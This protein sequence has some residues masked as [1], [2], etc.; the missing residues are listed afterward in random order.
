VNEP[1][2]SRIGVDAL[3]AALAAP[4]A[5]HVWRSLDELDASGAMGPFL[6]E[7]FPRY[8][9]HYDADRRQFLKLMS[10][11]LALAGLAG[12]TREPQEKILPYVD[13]P[14]GQV[15]GEPRFYATANT[16]GGFAM[17][18]LVESNMGRPTKVEGNPRHP[19]S[20][21][22]TDVFAQAGVLDLWDPDRSQAV[23]H[24]GEVST[25]EAFAAALQ[26]RMAK[27]AQREGDGLHVLTETV[28]SPTLVAQL[29]ALLARYPK[30]QWHQYDPVNRDNVYEGTR[31]AFGQ[32]LDVRHRFD[33]AQ[34][35][36]S[37]DADF[38]GTGHSRV[39]DARDFVNGHATHGAAGASSRL[40]AVASTPSLTSAFADHRVSLRAGDIEAVAR[41][42][43]KLI[44]LSVA[45]PDAIPGL[46]EAWLSACVRDLD[47]HR[48][49]SLVVA[50]EQQPPIVHAL[51]HAM[52]A[53]LGNAGTTVA[54]IEPVAGSATSH[55]Q[56]LRALADDLAAGAVDT[57]VVVGGNP[58]YCAP[59]DIGFAE[60]LRKVAMT[61][62]MGLHE[63]ETSARCQWHLP[64]AHF[65]EPLYAGRSAHELVSM[66]GEGEF[67]SGYAIVREFWQSRLGADFELGWKTALRDGIVANSAAA[68]RST[69]LRGDALAAAT[70]APSVADAGDDSLELIFVPDASVLDGRFANN[71]W[72]QELPRPMTK[73]TWDNA[74]LIAPALAGRLGLANEDVVELRYRDRTIEA[75][76]WIMPGH[77]DGAVSI[78]LGYGRKRAGRVGNAHGFD[79]YPLRTSDAPW[80]GRDLTVRKTSR[81]YRLS[82]TQ[83]HHSMEGRALIRVATLAEYR[84]NPRSAASEGPGNPSGTLYD[85]FPY[86]GYKWGM[87]VDLGACIGCS[88]CT[89]ACQAE[90]NIPTVGK[91]QVA[92]G[93]EMHWI[94]V[95]RYYDGSPDAP[96]TYFQPVPCMQCEHA[97]CEP[98]CPVEA[99]VHDSEGINVQVYNRCVGTRFCSNNCPYK[100][101]RFNFLRYNDHDTES[102]KGPRNPEVTVRMRGVMEKCNYCLQRIANGRIEADKENRRIR[103][104]EVVTACQAVCPTKAI[105]FG[106]LNDAASAVNAQKVSPL[107][108]ALLAEL[109][110]QPRTTYLAKLSNPN[111]DLQET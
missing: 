32:P 90:N 62:R 44:G 25:W 56:S 9:A 66:L 69:A 83:H 57:L 94:R 97:P 50:G 65:L 88:A 51:A 93:R 21:G 29:Q 26:Q 24:D 52:N 91:Q 19:A 95:D 22:S 75:A 35:V 4:R 70:S 20:L 64:A 28:T 12:C 15:A 1:A 33:S 59:S 39:R 84:R 46:S 14:V 53:R 80:F 6:A 104:G 108:Y 61:V 79:A 71:A 17:G 13:A 42:I 2:E 111:P 38:L 86:T 100:V 82:T 102:L 23:T 98:V 77:P 7:R 54:Y 37:L 58:V 41:R 87:A 55:G 92:L 72:L 10:A 105:T 47:T 60:R 34:V 27:L 45:A 107:N 81:T 96:R 73:L 109:D 5:A 68:E 85:P 99:S 16:V 103:D 18:V 30:A 67:R 78:S 106:D 76:V 43:G 11:S 31:A 40:Y 110:T 89:I 36:L 74:A 3:R 101:R 63:D 8:A 49:A 48:G